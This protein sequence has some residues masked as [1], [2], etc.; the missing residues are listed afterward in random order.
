LTLLAGHRQESE[1]EEE[2]QEEG[3]AEV[4]EG[5][6]LEGVVLARHGVEASV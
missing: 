4:E 2:G 5:C 6:L 3:K 1:A